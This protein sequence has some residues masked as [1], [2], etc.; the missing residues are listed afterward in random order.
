VFGQGV[1]YIIACILE[2]FS[3]ILRRALLRRAGFRGPSGV[4]FVNM[5]YAYAFEKCMR[6]AVLATEKISLITFAVDSVKSDSPKMQLYGLQ[7]LHD[8]LEKEPL[9]T[10]V[11][12]QLTTSTKTMT[13]LFNMLGWSSEGDKYIRSF[14]AKVMAKIADSLRVAHIPGAMQLIASLLD[15]VQKSSMSYPLL[16]I[17]I[18]KTGQGA[19]IQRPGSNEQLSPMLNWWKQM[20][21]Y[22]LIPA[23]EPFN[24]EE[25]NSRILKYWKWIRK[26]WSVPEEEQSTDQDLLPV[27]GLLI[28]DRLSS[29]DRENCIEISRATGLI[30]K[31]IQFTGN[32]TGVK[33][34]N[35][36]QQTLLKCS[37]LKLLRRLS[38]TEGKFGVTLRQEIA[39]HPFLL[40]N[41]AEILDDS[42]SSQQLRELTAE[43]LRN[44]A[45]DG[46]IKEEIG[47][48]RVIISRLMHAFL[49]HCSH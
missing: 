47:H 39:E 13:S 1:L 23:E 22:C 24:K 21:I 17:H 30:S 43:L 45:V 48:I 12:S 33:N 7:M 34:I 42:G 14:A 3:F 8:L 49:N 16:D 37:A 18:R 46:N 4:K 32:I 38:S 2:V 44:L 6:G 31:I 19:S 26:Y 20:A 28:L 29:F 40:S 27:L 41:L 11:I 9:N 35:E 5:Y 10:R 36:T 15:T 25:Q